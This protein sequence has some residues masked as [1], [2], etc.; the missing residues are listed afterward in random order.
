L[1]VGLALGAPRHRIVQQLA[2]EHVLLAAIGGIAGLVVGLWLTPGIVA[3]AAGEVP[4][5]DTIALDYRWT[6]LAAGL[7]LATALAFGLVPAMMVSSMSPAQA[8][9]Q[10]GPGA[11]DR[12]IGHRA[13]VASE[14]ALAVVLVVCAGLF[15]GT[16]IQLASQPVGF[17]PSG[18]AIVSIELTHRPEFPAV[19]AT[20]PAA[21]AESQQTAIAA[22]DEAR[23]RLHTGWTHT[24]A[25]IDALVE[26]P[27]I[28]A[29]AG[30]ASAPFAGP[31][32]MAHVRAYGMPDSEEQTVQRQVVTE[33]YFRT[34][35]VP[36]LRGRNFEASDRQG[37]PVTIVSSELERQFFAGAAV[38]KKLVQSTGGVYDVV[39]VVPNVKHYRLSDEDLP[40]F[41]VLD[42]ALE[43]VKHFIVRT[44][45]DR[46]AVLPLLRAAIGHHA[47]YMIVT[48]M[49]TMEDRLATSLAEERFRGTIATLF[50]G[51]ALLFAG[52]GLYSLAVR[53]VA[54]RRREIG[55][56]VAVGAR[57]VDVCVLVLRETMTTVGA[58]LFAGVPAAYAVFHLTRSL[59][60]G[61]SLMFLHVVVLLSGL[62]AVCA[63][64]GTL[65]PAYRVSCTDPV[66]AMQKW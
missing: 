25:L 8:V 47:P 58:G 55:I 34:L 54:E 12:F 7:V 26:V 27:G 66:R 65:L 36:I 2:V 9:S 43:S 18:L 46:A 50:G 17:D 51:A 64:I 39:A 61:A 59:V 52:I 14:V 21:T 11:R 16:V 24:A 3:L 60:F 45:G 6:V 31:S 53:W 4:G 10:D 30:A 28:V 32:R 63:L 49:T 57:P 44:S 13:I 37:V 35:R 38:G 48:S 42:L 1:A 15:G 56:R 62:L 5:L 23:R 33:D 40:T 20:N 22:R 19:V 41:Y 29:V